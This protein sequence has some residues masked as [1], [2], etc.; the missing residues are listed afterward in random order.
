MRSSA[1]LRFWI[2]GTLLAA[3]GCDAPAGPAHVDPASSGTLPARAATRAAVGEIYE[4][5]EFALYMPPAA[6]GPRAVIVALGG[7]NTRAFVTGE[8]FG[9]PFPPVEAALQAMGES[10]RRLADEHRVAI[11][12]TSL[13]S[14]QPGAAAD[15]Q[16]L[17]AIKA[18]A[19]ASGRTGLSTAPILLYGLSGGAPEASGFAARYP[20]RIVGL[21]L[22]VPETVVTLTTAAQRKVP[23]FMVLAEFDAFVDN[24]AL[25]QAFS[26]NRGGGALW[27]MAMEPGVPHHSFTPVHQATTIEWMGAVLNHRLAG[28]SG[29]LRTIKEQSGWL[30]NSSTG[31]VFPWGGYR[32]DRSTASWF[33]TRAVAQRWRTLIGAA[34]NAGS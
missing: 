3:S 17:D 19:D 32:G 21:F 16:V 22:K 26:T 6:E 28:S 31:Q 15:Q 14:I 7:P 27:A 18:G 11:L 34:S 8:T 13:A 24:G 4:L 5:G 25:T 23:T 1:A 33:P 2:L 20:E 10:L 12:G 29:Q 9:A 30:G